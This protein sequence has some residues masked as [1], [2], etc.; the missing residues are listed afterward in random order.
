[1]AETFRT[2]TKFA[3]LSTY[4]N[5]L[6]EAAPGSLQQADNVV[7][8][9]PGVVS[10]RRGQRVYATN[11][12]EM[13][14]TVPSRLF[15]VGNDLYGAFSGNGLPASDLVVQKIVAGSAQP[16]VVSGLG[17]VPPPPGNAAHSVETRNVALISTSNSVAKLVPDPTNVTSGTLAPSGVPYGLDLQPS[18][19][20]PSSAT[21][22]FLAGG[23]ASGYQAVF[24][25]TDA[26]GNTSLGAPSPIVA[27]ENPLLA[28]GV[29]QNPLNEYS[30]AV[31]NASQFTVTVT[32]VGGGLSGPIYVVQGSTILRAFAN[33][34]GA[35]TLT[36][37]LMDTVEYFGR[38]GS[39][40]SLVLP[41]QISSVTAGPPPVLT[42]T[43]SGPDPSALNGV[44]GVTFYQPFNSAAPA[45]PTSSTSFGNVS[46][47]TLTTI[48]CTNGS[49]NPGSGA[50]IVVA[51]VAAAQ[52][53]IVFAYS[54]ATSGVNF[55]PQVNDTLVL[56]G[57]TVSP[58][59][60]ASSIITIGSDTNSQQLTLSEFP[61][62]MEIYDHTFG[63]PN[64]ITYSVGRPSNASISLTIPSGIQFLA[65]LTGYS[66]F[67][68][69][70]RSW[71]QVPILDTGT[72]NVLQDMQL[73][74]QRD[75]INTD[76]SVTIVDIAPDATLGTDLYTS[77]RQ[78]TSTS[79]K[80]QP[81]VSSDICIYENTLLLADCYLPAS[82]DSQL[83]G[84]TH[85][86]DATLRALQPGDVIEFSGV[87]A[88]TTIFTAIASGSPTA[89]QFVIVTGTGSVTNDIYQTVLNLSK[90]VNRKF[91]TPAI[92]PATPFTESV[93][94]LSTAT[95]DSQGGNFRIQTSN[96]LG[97]FA[98]TYVPANG[99]P[100]PFTTALDGTTINP[101]RQQNMLYASQPSEPEAV[102]LV[103]FLPVGQSNTQILRILPVP[104][105]CIIM[106]PEGFFQLIGT[107]IS[108]FQ[109]TL[110]NTTAQLLANE[111]A[112]SIQSSIM[113]FT[114]QGLVTISQGGVQITSIA[115]NQTI[116]DLI[117]LPAFA[118]SSFAVSHEAERRYILWVPTL[119]TDTLP[120]QAFAYNVLTNAW[121]RWPIARIC[122]L[123]NR[124]DQLLYTGASG[125]AAA[126]VVPAVYQETSPGTTYPYG[127]EAI[128]GT[129]SVVDATTLKFTPAGTVDT[130]S[131][132]ANFP[133]G[134]ALVVPVVPTSIF[135]GVKQISGLV[136]HSS[137]I[138]FT[139]DSTNWLLADT[140]GCSLYQ[141]IESVFAPIPIYPDDAGTV[142][143]FQEFEVAF[144]NTDCPT[145]TAQLATDFGYDTT[146]LSLAAIGVSVGSGYGSGT[147]GAFPWGTS[148]PSAPVFNQNARQLVT[149][150]AARGH[151][152]W[153]TISA[154][155]ACNGFHCQGITLAWAPT[156]SLRSR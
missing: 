149:R 146:N 87:E 105:A 31:T 118:S 123:A 86:A 128:S 44:S 95:A 143:Q 11:G 49:F 69:L 43:T 116:L 46:A 106:K 19:S 76:Q 27:L 83:L 101:S 7:V 37:Y 96:G 93:T 34:S 80:Y 78:G 74:F 141:G 73:A 90:A 98:V 147:W 63:I 111:T 77:P 12:G 4:P 62:G 30:T 14:D 91:I 120:T 60:T 138:T 75:L 125:Q 99:Q 133:D 23:F 129:I 72:T 52:Q 112:V 126:P 20:A 85:S 152:W 81:P 68:Q 5:N 103:N 47:T 42:Y 53:N 54:S 9:K 16:A 94:L 130:P 56:P 107:D 155:V 109:I 26:Q 59:V 127:D 66:C 39:L 65:G 15:Q 36:I 2:G 153:P 84:V 45:T 115:I 25:V 48:T 8:D 70:Y 1:M 136:D 24:G 137:Y 156:R 58:V 102:P 41:V 79:A 97:T 151:Y 51:R 10:P 150:N 21:Q 140:A 117:N 18:L 67:V 124:A 33:F 148:N 139:V 113:A 61:S 29:I 71:Q 57:S 92:P 50:V 38:A 17:A 64:S 110:L 13:G 114:N 55:T 122:G 119:A 104:G 3:G 121:V 145:I 134:S 89:N 82:I 154:T 132:V 88:G 6:S 135:A 28:G 40:V 108:N 32:G 100:S 131:V 142:K 35:N 144:E 22:G